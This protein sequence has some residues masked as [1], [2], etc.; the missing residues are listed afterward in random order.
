[1]GSTQVSRATARLRSRSLDRALIAGVDP[2]ATPQL[3]AHTARITTRST[4][5]RLADSLDRLAR[6]DAQPVTRW[7][8]RPFRKA[9]RANATELHALAALLR[10]RTAVRAQGIA[11]LRTLVTDGTGPVYADRDGDWLAERLQDARI[12]TSAG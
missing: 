1:M 5:V 9:A 3:A 8:V 6:S 10:G 11:M 7:R 4:R 2:S 12:A